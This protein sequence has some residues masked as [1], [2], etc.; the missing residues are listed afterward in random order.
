[1]KAR[2]LLAIITLAVLSIKC[3]EAKKHF[4][5]DESKLEAQYKPQDI[6]KLNIVNTENKDI[7]KEPKA[8]E[9]NTTPNQEKQ[10]P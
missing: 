1:M 7:E 3:G 4:S 5:I 6:L 10:G 2:N 8:S 9:A